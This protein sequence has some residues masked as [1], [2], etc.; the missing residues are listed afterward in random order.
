[1]LQVLWHRAV[2]QLL[3]LLRVRAVCSMSPE[4][5]PN[6]GM[7]GVHVHSGFRRVHL[8]ILLVSARVSVR[9]GV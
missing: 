2:S 3:L 5:S 6:T 7:D 8:V 1:M 9:S 4:L